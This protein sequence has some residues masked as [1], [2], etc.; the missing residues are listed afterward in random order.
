SS[1]ACTVTS[2]PASNSTSERFPAVSYLSWI[3]FRT[4]RGSDASRNV[5]EPANTYA[6]AWFVRSTAS[7]L[8]VPGGTDTSRYRGSAATPSIGPFV[9]H[10]TPHITRRLLPSSRVVSGR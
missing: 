10:H 5:P 8:R 9:S 6:N 4:A 1:P 3:S 2:S 7:L